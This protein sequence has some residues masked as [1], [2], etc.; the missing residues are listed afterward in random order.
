MNDFLSILGLTS[1]AESRR[2]E[3]FFTRGGHSCHRYCPDAVWICFLLWSLVTVAPACGRPTSSGNEIGTDP[4]AGKLEFFEKRVRPVLA[5]HCYNCHSADTKPA[6][7]LRVDDRVGLLTG[8]NTGPAIVPGDPENSLLIK[9]LRHDDPKKRMPPE[10]DPV[11]DPEVADLTTWIADGAVWPREKIPAAIG[12]TRADYQQ[13]KSNHWSLQ[14]LVHATVPVVARKPWPD[15]NIDHFVLAKLESHKL[16]PTDDA[17]RITLI[18]RVTFDLTGLPPT[19][20]QINAFLRDPS[21]TAFEKVVDRLLASPQYA[22]RWGRHWL[23]VARYGES[24][25]PSRNIPYPQAWRFRDYVIDAFNRDVP[26]NRFIQEQI[27]GDLIS[28]DEPKERDRLL[29]ATGFLALGVKDVNQRFKGRYIMDN[30]DEQMDVVMRSVMGL[31]VGCARC[32]DHKF[33]PI[34]ST[35]YYALAGIFTSTEDCSGLRN[36]M[37]GSGLDYYAPEM[38]RIVS[39]NSPGVSPEKIEALKTEIAEAKK[40]WETVRDTPDGMAKDDQGVPKQRT[41]K[42]KVDALEE[43]LFQWNDPLIKGRAVHG[44]R[45]SAH[46]GD[47]EYRVR[48]EAERLGPKIPRQFLSAFTLPDTQP[49]PATDSGR[50]Q[51]AYWLTSTNNPLTS[52]VVINRVWQKLF[53]VGLVSTVDN[54]GV[55]GDVPS[56]PELLDYL[57]AEFMADGWSIKRLVR[58][59]VVSHAY[60]LGADATPEQIE[61][62][63][64]N[65]WLWRHSPRRLDAEEIRDAMIMAADSL[66]PRPTDDSA[67]KQLK[68]IEVADN[69]PEAKSINERADREMARSVY[70]PLMRGIT[71]GTMDAF[72]PVDQTTVSG[73]RDATTVPTQALYFLNSGFVRLLSL[74]L[75]E[76]LASQKT[77]DDEDAIQRAYLLTLSRP[78]TSKEIRLARNYLTE[79]AN[80]Y[81]E[82]KPIDPVTTM[83]VA[84]ANGLGNAT[85]AYS[86]PPVTNPDDIGRNS[87]TTAEEAIRAKS[88][89]ED[90]RAS[91]IQA[92]FASA[93]FRFV[94]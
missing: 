7:G 70:L 19:P 56:H 42:L 52:R 48:G 33:D 59:M 18:R 84:C 35:D 66:Q 94:R 65:R 20:G 64:N 3:C 34:P 9:R 4:D 29:V 14:P 74:K 27:A 61:I 78:P 22:E 62:D 15:G 54:F 2:S 90:A 89:E 26:F 23:D 88:A 36:K 11:A 51:L 60:R 68:M 57:A 10:G 93:E 73:R 5:N 37:G 45:D 1:N 49:I 81:R 38:L 79:Y 46:P 55:K 13:L 25:G 32:H 16:S 50:L 69:G 6:G 30:V 77:W 85:G 44:V 53:G 17:D 91:F 24:T 92:L 39:L 63:P 21:S 82:Q 83:P 31:T 87:E 58:R 43:Q 76:N 71:P 47:T 40:Q 41:L 12:R 67:V 8:G 86:A 28:A 75:A 72:D 80:L